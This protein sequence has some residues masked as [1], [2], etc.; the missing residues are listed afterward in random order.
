MG[1]TN[2]PSSLA[3]SGDA[4]PGERM[5]ESQVVQRRRGGGMRDGKLTLPAHNRQ[6][7]ELGSTGS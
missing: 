7:S 2:L 5:F 3:G 1:A 4:F 6:L